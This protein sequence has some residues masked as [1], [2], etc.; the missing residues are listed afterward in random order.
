MV[1]TVLLPP[2][3]TLDWSKGVSLGSAILRWSLS[4]GA[5]KCNSAEP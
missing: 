2:M 3:D 1:G 5:F 4:S